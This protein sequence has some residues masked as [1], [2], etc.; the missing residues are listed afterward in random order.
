[1]PGN[2]FPDREHVTSVTRF[3]P[4]RVTDPHTVADLTAEVFLAAIGSAH[5]YGP[6][7]GTRVAW[8]YGIE[9]VATQRSL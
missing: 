6:G 4:R 1:M 5:T 8:L 7:Q 3:V 2:P 9:L